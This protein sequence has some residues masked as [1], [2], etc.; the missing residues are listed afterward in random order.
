MKCSRPHAF[1]TLKRK[2]YVTLTDQSGY[3]K[4]KLTKLETTQQVRSGTDCKENKRNNSIST[5][6]NSEHENAVFQD[7]HDVYELDLPSETSQAYLHE[8]QSETVKHNQQGQIYLT[9][10]LMTVI[11]IVHLIVKMIN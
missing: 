11:M 1:K 7:Y 3:F 2:L 5:K 4:G 10:I 9:Q 6:E 8:S